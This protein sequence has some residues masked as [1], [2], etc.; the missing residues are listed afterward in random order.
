MARAGLT[1][2]ALDPSSVGLEA[3]RRTAQAEKLDVRLVLGGFEEHDE[4]PGHYGGVFAFGLIPDLRWEAIHRLRDRCVAW[5]APGG[6]LFVTGFTTED[7]AVDRFRAEWREVG[8]G[9]FID[10]K[11][12]GGGP[13]SPGE[14]VRTYLAPG[15][16]LELFSSL[17]VLSH[18]EGLG[19]EHCHGDGPPERHGRF[20]VV[21]GAP[22]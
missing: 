10:P 2:D 9:S 16:V 20:E 12:E 17:E 3:L 18:W 22:T 4:P 15:Q 21:L 13:E 1:V 7:P 6:L 8:E 19:P 5:L 11:G 14:R